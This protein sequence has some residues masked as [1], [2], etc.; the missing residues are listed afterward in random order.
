ME[1]KKEIND[2]IKSVF[3]EYLSQNY[4]VTYHFTSISALKDI[5]EN[6]TLRLTNS[7]YLNDRNEFVDYLHSQKILLQNLKEEFYNEFYIEIEEKYEEEIIAHTKFKNIYQHA[8][9]FI[10]ST[11]SSEKAVPM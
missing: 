4:N 9:Y 10:F 2:K 7:Q 11:S 8:S 1:S 3:N 6:K 5:V